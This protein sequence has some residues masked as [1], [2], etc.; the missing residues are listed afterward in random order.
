MAWV[1][2]KELGNY[3]PASLIPKLPAEEW[4][5]GISELHL[6]LK[7]Q[8]P[9]QSKLLYLEAVKQFKNYGATFFTAKVRLSF[10]NAS[11]PVD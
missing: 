11:F 6:K 5:K 8:N 3:I 9:I 10:N 7:D 4:I 1:P 2:S